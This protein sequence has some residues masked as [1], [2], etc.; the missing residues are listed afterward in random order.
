MKTKHWL[1]DARLTTWWLDFSDLGWPSP[2]LTEKWEHRARVFQEKGANG[3]V[4]S[5]FHFR[6]DFH[7]LFERVFGALAEIAKICH[8][9]DLHVVE[10]HS[11][12][13]VHRVRNENDRRN[14]RHH[15]KYHVP[16]FP[17]NWENSLYGGEKV[18]DWLQVSALADEISFI[19]ED[20]CNGFCPNHPGFQR[21]YL[22]YILR[23]V[24]AIPVDA[25]ISEDLSF[26]PDVYS[27]SCSHCRKRFQEEDGIALPPAS[28]E[29]FWVNRQ[30]PDF[31]AWLR[32][33][34]RWQVEHYKRLRSVLPEEV[35]LWA[36]ASSCISPE[37]ADTGSSP[38]RAADCFDAVCHEI[39]PNWRLDSDLADITAE[40]AG[41]T[42]LARDQ[43]KPL[44]TLCHV[45]RPE[46]LG[47][48]LRFLGRSHARPWVSKQ[49][50]YEDSVPEEELLADGFPFAANLKKAPPESV[51]AVAFSE[52]FRDSLD[53]IE[54]DDY[55]ETYRALSA[56]LL[57]RGSEPHLLFDDMWPAASPDEWECLWILD[58][59]ALNDEQ[60]RMVEEWQKAGLPVGIS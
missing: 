49:T 40:L 41:F 58:F 13:R 11:A 18:A 27:C 38:Q 4:L 26:L 34:Y 33:R 35:L 51:Q 39:S 17:D 47:E 57:S 54:A 21:A 50:R 5:G 44:V 37:L 53:P 42:S 22:D 31:R 12:T 60:S 56:E 32:A 10:R 29:Q 2:R 45:D 14:I 7:F 52:R 30:N 19:E 8:Q 20:S 55:V 1:N 43:K 59:R 36:S 46:E 24:A 48:W 3:V 15:H 28:D 6:W 23:Y 16:F 9:H 25:V